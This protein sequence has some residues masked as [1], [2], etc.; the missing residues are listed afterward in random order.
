MTGYRA[1]Y[2]G[3]LNLRHRVIPGAGHIAIGDGFGPWPPM[4]TWCLAGDEAWS[5]AADA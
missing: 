5:T 3:S 4:L 2:T 1:T